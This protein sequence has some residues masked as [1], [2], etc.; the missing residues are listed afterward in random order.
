[1]HAKQQR[2]GITMIAS[3]LAAGSAVLAFAEPDALPEGTTPAAVMKQDTAPGSG[4]GLKA[5]KAA[6]IEANKSYWIPAAEIFAFDLTL[7]VFNRTF[8][9]DAYKS[10]AASI[11]KNLQSSWNTDSDPFTTNQLGHPYQ[12]SVYHT[13]ARS[14]GLNYWE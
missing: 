5:R 7:N 8:V 3:M 12:G 4:T 10:T 6:D 14:A 13:L 9:D 2:Y 11:R 1:M